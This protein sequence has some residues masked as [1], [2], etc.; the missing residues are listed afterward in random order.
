MKSLH[1]VRPQWLLVTLITILALV[2]S[3]LVATPRASAAP[4]DAGHAIAANPPLPERCGGLSM[5]LVFDVSG[6]IGPQGLAQSKEAGKAVVDALKDT[7]TQ[8]GIYNFATDSPAKGQQNLDKTPASE[9]ETLNDHIDK[10][11]IPSN[12]AD[13]YTNWQKALSEVQ[14]KDYT[15]VYLITDGQPNK[16]GDGSG[17]GVKSAVQ[18]AVE[19]ANSLKNAGTRVVPLAVGKAVQPGTDAATYLGYI[20]GDD[21]WIPVTQ[22]TELS[23]TLVEQATKG[24]QGV[25]NIEKNF[26]NKRGK[27]VEPTAPATKSGWKFSIEDAKADDAGKK[28]V[29][30]DEGAV[31]TD[32]SGAAVLRYR[33][34]NPNTV[35]T[36][37]VAEANGEPKSVKCTDSG[38]AVDVTLEGGKFTVPAKTGSELSCTV[39]NLDENAPGSSGDGSSDDPITERCLPAV[40][41]VISALLLSLPLIALG[42]AKAPG[43]MAVQESIGKQIQ[44]ANSRIQQGTGIYNEDASRFAAQVDGQLKAFAYNNQ[45]ALKVLGTL[46]ALAGAAG[47]LWAFCAPGSGSSGNQITVGD[48]LENLS[49]SKKSDEEST[50]EEGSGSKGSS[51]KSGSSAKPE[52]EKEDAQED[53]AS[54][55]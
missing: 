22:Y 1:R 13:R 21:D 54:A 18:T 19:A 25:I 3:V 31:V 8:I 39:S 14:G 23:A 16:H 34:S 37:T 35:G 42:N 40:G 5:A 49:S 7:D 46:A 29:A 12:G 38:V 11:A 51:S 48:A 26:V 6:S 33:T 41:G 15:V 53:V 45:D 47:L 44:E 27:V 30:L 32:E 10:L 2:A 4:V 36:V 43:I 24:C 28:I 55:A 52:D 9:Q 50:P 20:S 17:G